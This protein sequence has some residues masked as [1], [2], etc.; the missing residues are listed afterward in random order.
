MADGEMMK[1]TEREEDDDEKGR[2]VCRRDERYTGVG[3]G[4]DKEDGLIKSCRGGWRQRGE[5]P[6]VQNAQKGI[7]RIFEKKIEEIGGTRGGMTGCSHL[8]ELWKT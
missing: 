8:K 4:G 3:L 1:T 7:L 6:L 5:K 2:W